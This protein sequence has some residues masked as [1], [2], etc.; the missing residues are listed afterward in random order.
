M[1]P[2]QNINTRL[3]MKI[4]GGG[5][6]VEIE[7]IRRPSTHS[8]AGTPDAQASGVGEGEIGRKGRRWP[9]CSSTSENPFLANL[10]I[11]N[12]AGAEEHP[13]SHPQFQGCP[14]LPDCE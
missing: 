11:A 1:S 8:R 12:D 14:Q 3:V 5:K 4:C 10:R 13:S 7:K 6:N 9:V 2:F